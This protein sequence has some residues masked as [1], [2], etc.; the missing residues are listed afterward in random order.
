MKTSIQKFWHRFLPA[1]WRPQIN[2]EI[3][4]LL[5][6]CRPAA[7]RFESRLSIPIVDSSLDDQ[8]KAEAQER[9]MFL[10]RQDRWDDLA[11]EMR[12]AE[13]DRRATP[14]GMPI[15]ELMA[16][17]ARADVVHAVEHALSDNI[18]RDDSVLL[19]GIMGLE[20]VLCEQKGD[21]MIALIVAL[22]HIDIGWAWRGDG[23]D[24][25]LPK[26]NRKRCAA[27]FDR[28]AA[29]L[30]PH[31]GVS[32]DSPALLA[33]CCALWAGR[34]NAG[35]QL[36]DKYEALIDLVPQNHRYMRTMG[37]HLLPK[38]RGSYE[39]LELE[40]RRTASRTEQIWGA[41]GYTWVCFDAIAIDDEA[42]AR[43]DVPFFLDGLRDIVSRRPDQ[44]TVN[45][46]AAFCAV[47][48]R[49]GFGDN[50]RAELAREQISEAADWL[51]RDHLTEL[52]PLIWA[53]AA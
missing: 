18:S 50:E 48:L 38:W 7:D 51:I 45:L 28:A 23:W 49:D 6:D 41:G 4:A 13:R 17:G 5:P 2:P 12:A 29:V 21:P 1:A 26:L 10:A 47:T 9:G 31:C 34:E 8:G 35:K 22:A 33:A 20:R 14:D 42:C 43:V 16:Y 44:R 37:V 3:V 15:A 32:L 11:D 46:L 27:H 53:H 24:S 25:M 19:D 36:A 52:H 39:A 40:A 30:E